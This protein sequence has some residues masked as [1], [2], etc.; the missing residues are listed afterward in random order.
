M[1]DGYVAILKMKSVLPNCVL[2]NDVSILSINL[3]E[4]EEYSGQ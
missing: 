1:Y 4:E 3:G 2:A